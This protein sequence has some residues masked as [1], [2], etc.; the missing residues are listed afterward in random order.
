MPRN[1]YCGSIELVSSR[2][3]A[4]VVLVP[5]LRTRCHL[6]QPERTPDRHC[7]DSNRRENQIRERMAEPPLELGCH[8][9][10]FRSLESAP[11]GLQPNRSRLAGYPAD[12]FDS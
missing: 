11:P 8:P 5:V 4:D 6:D 3:P 9:M 10:S 1:R 12:E 2:I 7:L